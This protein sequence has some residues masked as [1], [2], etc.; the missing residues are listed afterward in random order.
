MHQ[1]A[2]F[3]VNFPKNSRGRP[4]GPQPAGGGDPLPHSPPF[5]ALRL[6]L[7]SASDLIGAPAVFNRAPEEKKLDTPEISF[8][9]Y[10]SYI[11]VIVFESTLS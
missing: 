1:N 8:K 4:P 3:W 7:S 11:I 2:P 5:G 6:R 9:S 10:I